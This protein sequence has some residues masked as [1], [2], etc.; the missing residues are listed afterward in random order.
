[1]T[2]RPLTIA[3]Y[4]KYANSRWPP[5][6]SFVTNETGNLGLPIRKHS[7]DR[8]AL[9]DGN[10][11]ASKFTET[12]GQVH[13]R[14]GSRRPESPT[15]TPASPARCSGTTTTGELVLSFRST[16]FVDDHARDSAGHQRRWR[17]SAPALPSARS[18]DMEAWYQPQLL[19]DKGALA[20]QTY[21][22]TGYSL[23]GHLATVF[24]QL[25]QAEL[26]PARRPPPSTRSSPSTAPA[27]ARSNGGTLNDTLNY[28]NASCAP[29]RRRIKAA[30]DLTLD[31]LA[32]T[33]TNKSRRTS[34]TAPGRPRRP[35][36]RAQH[37]SMPNRASSRP[38]PASTLPADAAPRQG[39]LDAIITLQEEA[40]RIGTSP[41]AARTT[42]LQ[43]QAS[44]MRTK[45]SPRPS[46][47]AL[48]SI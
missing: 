9:I 42:G 44:A 17:S 15:P 2:C 13:R 46:T 11:H 39:S 7:C 37:P 22:V 41:P 20:G 25:R 40:E 33:S 38:H 12:E 36:Y 48:P 35:R 14:M 1:M 31:R 23:G 16:E 10:D 34:P 18:A 30:L 32:P 21:S 24:N 29:T 8:Q 6:H 43:S 26:S 19:R 45:S 5:K 28:F 47:T 3:D 4:L 27:S